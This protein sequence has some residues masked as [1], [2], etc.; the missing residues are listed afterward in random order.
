MIGVLR[1]VDMTGVS[2]EVLGRGVQWQ[3]EG[4]REPPSCEFMST[5]GKLMIPNFGCNTLYES[6]KRMV[7]VRGFA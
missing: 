3:M 1:R 7:G 4:V 6:V 2:R 5:M